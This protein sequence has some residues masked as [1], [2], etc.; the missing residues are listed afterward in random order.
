MLVVQK[1]ARFAIVGPLMPQ[2][3]AA[4]DPQRSL[5]SLSC[6]TVLCGREFRVR[7]WILAAVLDPSAA[8]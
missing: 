7:I 6:Q 2:F 1:C 3:S 5:M 8:K 4:T